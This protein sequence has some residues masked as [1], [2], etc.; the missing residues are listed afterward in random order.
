[1]IYDHLD[2]LGQ[3]ASFSPAFAKA[4]AWVAATDLA[5]LPSDG[6]RIAIDGEAVFAIPHTYQTLAPG[7]EIIESHRRYHDI[8][9]LVEGEEIIR[10]VPADTQAPIVDPYQVEREAQFHA[11]DTPGVEV[12]MRPGLFLFLTPTDPHGPNRPLPGAAPRWNRKVVIKV[13]V[14]A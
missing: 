4:A 12:P 2:R 8:Q 11:P 9:I 5:S 3:Y 14:E 13:Q 6:Q 10:V 1:M 7:K